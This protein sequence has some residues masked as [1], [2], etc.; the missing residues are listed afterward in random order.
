MSA[1]PPGSD[2][3][4][5]ELEFPPKPE[6]VR[7]ARLSVAALARLHEVDDEVV[8]DIKLAVSEA[9]TE[10]VVAGESA[11]ADQPVRLRASVDLPQLA[12]EVSH[13][14]EPPAAEVSGSPSEIDTEDLPFEQAL[15]L[16]IIR[17][18]VDEV[19]LGPGPDGG[20]RLRMRI[21]LEPR[22]EQANPG[23]TPGSS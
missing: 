10:A 11:A 6:Y 21:S 15:A 2:R 7:L 3:P 23:S 19:A 22:E 5:L 18:L 16:P 4:E 8:E 12:V 13:A 20:T 9:S 17:G 1:A 14:G